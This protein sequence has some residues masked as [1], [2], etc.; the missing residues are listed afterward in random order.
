[1]RKI[2]FFDLKVIH[3]YYDGTKFDPKR[4]APDFKFVMIPGTEK[5]SS[6]KI[7]IRFR[8]TYRFSQDTKDMLSFIAEDTYEVEDIPSLTLSELKELLYGSFARF[9]AAF[10]YKLTENRIARVASLNLIDDSN[11]FQRCLDDLKKEQNDR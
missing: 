5:N 7:A 2:G 1:M 3:W 6:K 10:E 9:K 8:W 11:E 4:A